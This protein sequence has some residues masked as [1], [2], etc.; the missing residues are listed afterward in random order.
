MPL[1][2]S[3][4]IELEKN[5]VNSN[6]YSIFKISLINYYYKHI[7]TEKYNALLLIFPIAGLFE[8]ELKI[9]ENNWR[10]R[11]LVSVPARSTE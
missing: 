4:L 11:I 6:M 1:N 3:I 2:H 8:N 9:R 7:N 5:R 10:Y